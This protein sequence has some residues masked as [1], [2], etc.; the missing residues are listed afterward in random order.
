M[1]THA[2]TRSKSGLPAR[3]KTTGTA[4]VKNDVAT[5]AKT[6]TTTAGLSMSLGDYLECIEMLARAGRL[7]RVRDIAKEMKVKTPS[8]EKGLASLKAAG[9]VT[10]ERYGAVELTPSGKARAIELC[11]RHELLKKFLI[12]LGVDEKT[13]ELDGCKM[14]HFLSG[15]TLARI[16]EFLSAGSCAE[17]AAAKEAET[18]K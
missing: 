1:K 14:E 12:R 18:A 11:E 9:L 5:R 7:A 3:G 6:A 2:T 4:R 17:Q 15:E 13:A 16:S 8:V 10:Q